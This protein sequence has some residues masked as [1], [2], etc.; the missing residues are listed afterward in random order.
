MWKSLLSLLLCCALIT[1]RQTKHDSNACAGWSKLQPTLETAVK[2][3]MND[4]QFAGSG[5]ETPSGA[6]DA[7]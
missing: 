1:G 2:I 7:E 4:R 5:K 3:T 6:A